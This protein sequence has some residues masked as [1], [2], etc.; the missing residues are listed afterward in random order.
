VKL[1]HVWL[2]KREL[3]TRRVRSRPF[4]GINPQSLT[5]SMDTGIGTNIQIVF[6]HK[7]CIINTKISMYPVSQVDPWTR[8]TRW[9]S[10]SL[11]LS[12]YSA[13]SCCPPYRHPS[14]CSAGRCYRLCPH[15]HP[16]LRQRMLLV[17][18]VLRLPMTIISMRLRRRHE[19]HL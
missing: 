3:E 11:L 1:Y 12:L 15:Q 9:K 18:P 8:R 13:G 5:S 2:A 10:L 4:T 6:Q 14:L 7:S 17:P 19:I 16:G